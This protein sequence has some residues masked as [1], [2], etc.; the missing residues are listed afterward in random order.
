MKVRYWFKTKNW[1]GMINGKFLILLTR[2]YNQIAAT[3][4]TGIEC[5]NETYTN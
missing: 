4:Y 1:E 5:E 3:G 2:Y